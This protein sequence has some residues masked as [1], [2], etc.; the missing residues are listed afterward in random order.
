L[1]EGLDCRLAKTLC[2]GRFERLDKLDVFGGEI[3]REVEINDVVKK[4]GKAVLECLDCLGHCRD[5]FY[6]PNV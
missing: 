3:G 6:L 1:R 2:D 5:S 4:R